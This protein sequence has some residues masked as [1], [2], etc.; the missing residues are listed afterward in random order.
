MDAETHEPLI[1][2]PVNYGAI[3]NINHKLKH[4]ICCADSV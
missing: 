1:F 3:G 2:L 4:N